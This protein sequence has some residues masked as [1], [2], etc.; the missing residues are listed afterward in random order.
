M[1]ARSL[2]PDPCS[3]VAEGGFHPEPWWWLAALLLAATICAQSF[4][5]PGGDYLRPRPRPAATRIVR[6][7]PRIAFKPAANSNLPRVA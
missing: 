3:L 2:I 7:G 6:A 5:D 1:T 4:A